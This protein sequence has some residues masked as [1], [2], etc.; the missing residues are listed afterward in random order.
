MK[1]IRNK[2]TALKK[3]PSA[4]DIVFFFFNS[5]V[6]ILKNNNK[7]FNLFKKKNSKSEKTSN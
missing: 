4:D 7:N 6:Y 2:F 1:L 5:Q 3:K